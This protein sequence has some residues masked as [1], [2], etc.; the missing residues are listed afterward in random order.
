MTILDTAPDDS[1]PAAPD[2]QKASK[3]LSDRLIQLLAGLA[4]PLGAVLAAFTIG[5][6]MLLALGANPLRGTRPCSTE[7][8]A[9]GMRWPTRP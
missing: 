3:G 7:P 4:V 6:I 8:L 1:T 5:A 2:P 9:A